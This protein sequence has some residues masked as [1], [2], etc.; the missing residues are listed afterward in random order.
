[1]VY[2][3][4][5]GKNNP[6]G[7]FCSACGT[8]LI[9]K[10]TTKVYIIWS[11]VAITLLLLVTEA[12]AFF[13]PTDAENIF[14]HVKRGTM[15][16]MGIEFCGNN[17]CNPDELYMCK[18]D[19]VWCGDGACQNEEIGNCY[20]D[21]EWCGDG[22]CQEKESCDSCS[23]DC[24]KCKASA[25]CGDG[26]C[27]AGE[28]ALGCYKDCS[29]S[30]CE[31]GVCESQKG[32]NCVTSPN[33]CRCK[34]NEKCNRE[35]KSCEIILCGDGKC[36][37][38]ENLLSCPNDCKE[39]Y[40][41]VFL[42][43]N[44]DFPVIFVHGHSPSEVKGYSPT[45]LEEFQDKL[46]EQGYEDM[47]I[48]LPSDYP[49]KLTKGIWSGKKVSVIMTYYANKYDKLGGVVG[50]E[51]NQRITTYSQRLRD[52]VEVVKHNTGKNKVIIIAHS[53]GGLVSRSYIKYYGGLESVDKLVTI[54][55]PNH[56][57]YGAVAFGCGTILAG[58]NPTPECEDMNANSDF[59]IKLNANDETPSNIK[60]LTII[61][62]NKKLDSCPDKG[63]TDN[64]I[65]AASV[66]LDGAEN[67]YYDDFSPNY[68]LTNSLHTAFVSP[69][70]APQV[71]NKIVQFIKN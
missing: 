32:E 49:P 68:S 48:M 12:I 70:K 27:N 47:G 26:V 51:D 60:Y 5:C 55:T 10:S 44:I 66:Y 2:C 30:Q 33:D 28:C 9:R 24:G 41:Q 59:L 19:C 42:D 4:K 43:S 31:N 57:T 23:K 17:Q 46:A 40:S 54:G 56:G 38:G 7:K 62:K 29:I 34:F 36:D 58:R 1:M 63:Y 37:S 20:D 8:A 14:G 22:Y 69:S 39:K 64:V 52:V 25:Y 21:C 18:K 35:S 45:S 11:L 53:M 15:L 61:G 16:L 50:P 6:K 65:C 3:K 13:Q 71:Y 67:Y